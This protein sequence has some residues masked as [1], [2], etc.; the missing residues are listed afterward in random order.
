MEK[1]RS[2]GV[3]IFSVYIIALSLLN[4][5]GTLSAIIKNLPNTDIILWGN[6]GWL[7][8]IPDLIVSLL[9]I[10]IAIGVLRLYDKS[11]KY[12]IYLNIYDVSVAIAYQALLFATFL[13]RG[14][15]F[16]EISPEAKAENILLIT[17]TLLSSLICIYFFTRPKVKE[18]FK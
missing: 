16:A 9:Y 2:K 15:G 12:L 1:K 14:I 17:F 11:R 7:F 3:T 4:I 13:I 10:A 18:Q 8:R 5:W 6:V